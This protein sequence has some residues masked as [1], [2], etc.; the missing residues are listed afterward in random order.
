MSIVA[1]SPNY[2]QDRG[3]WSGIPCRFA[4]YSKDGI[5]IRSA[6]NGHWASVPCRPPSSD[7]PCRP[8]GNTLA[9]R[10]FRQSSLPA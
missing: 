1:D 7:C 9:Y 4:K 10:R 6:D 2:L 8:V 3:L 5:S